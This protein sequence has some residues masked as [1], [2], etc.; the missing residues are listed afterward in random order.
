[1]RARVADPVPFTAGIVAGA[2]QE[3]LV[4]M[5][6][7]RAHGRV[8]PKGVRPAGAGPRSR[9]GPRSDFDHRHVLRFARPQPHASIPTVHRS[10]HRGKR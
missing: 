2:R 7:H 1:V 10:G 6:A 4:P 5:P 3:D 9:R 8:T